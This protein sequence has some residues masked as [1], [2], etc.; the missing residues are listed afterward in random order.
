MKK[1][2]IKPYNNTNK[3]KSEEIEEMFDNISSS[4]DKLNSILSLGIDKIWKKKLLST[5]S[6]IELKN[7]LDCACGSGAV[8]IS[9]YKKFKCNVTGID[10]SSK[11]L[12]LAKEKSCKIKQLQFLKMNGENL[13]F[14]DN[15]FDAVT[16]AY[17]IRNY[18]NP[19]KGLKEMYRV[20]NKNGI[21]I[22][23]ELSQPK[24]FFIRSLYNFYFYNFI[25]TIGKLISKDSRAYSY[26]PKSV[27][28]F[29]QNNLFIELL[30]KSGF[31]NCYFKT[32]TMG[33]CTLYFGKK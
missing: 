20:L 24:N 7:V 25:P 30:K 9:I 19:L 18:N 17:G 23:L 5:L 31:K 10:L 33:T 29:P 11:M 15:K 16:I 2:S 6:S 1:K 3:T 4:Y 13:G 8:S 32:M 27:S 21:I 28:N 12:Q 14:K 22:V 26:L